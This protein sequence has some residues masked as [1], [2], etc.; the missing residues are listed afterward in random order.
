[1]ADGKRHAPP[2]PERRDEDPL[3]AAFPIRRTLP[4][5]LFSTAFHAAVLV[6]LATFSFAVVKRDLI[7]VK[8]EPGAFPE[9]PDHEGWASLKDVAGVLHPQRFQRA[10]V[11]SVA[12]PSTNR[13]AASAVRAPE[14]PRISGVAPSIGNV[15]GTLEDIPLSIG[16]GGLVGGGLGG[17]G[18][19]GEIL[20]LRKTGIDLVLVVDTTGSMQSVLDEVKEQM[21]RFIAD[22][23]QMVKLSRVAVVAY[24]D[25]GEEYLVKWV[26][27]SFHTDKVQ[28]FVAGLRADGG[29]DYEEA[30]KQGI[31]TA[32]DELTWRKSARHILILIGGTP[33][34]KEDREALLKLVRD[35]EAD[36][37]AVGAIDVTRR[38][39]EEYDRSNWIAKGSSGTFKISPMPGFYRETT[40]AYREIARAGGGEVL[41]LGSQKELLRQVM[42]LTFGTRWRVEMA[43]FMDRLR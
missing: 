43:G 19:G 15:P 8:I 18:F 1:V 16:G 29:G 32:V 25:R 21:R 5:F 33:P 11:R 41:E 27:F 39:H 17:G 2:L 42:V 14:M 30:V 26:D 7:P 34:H 35:F 3:G 10:A 40:D 23:Q 36:N 20:G 24:R 9:E 22:L 38:L 12:Q 6:L 31:E 13:P 37:G 28:E 4:A